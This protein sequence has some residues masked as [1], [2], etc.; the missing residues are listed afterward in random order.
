VNHGVTLLLI[1]VEGDLR[2]TVGVI[3]NMR[4]SA[5]GSAQLLKASEFAR[6]TVTSLKVTA[7]IRLLSSC[8]SLGSIQL[9]MQ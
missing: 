2:V 3:S 6:G 9:R 7:F 5:G 1:P 8:Q 4:S